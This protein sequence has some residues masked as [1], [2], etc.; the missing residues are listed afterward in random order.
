MFE[1]EKG[2]TGLETAIILIAFVVV[3][4]VLAYTVLSAG[5]FATQQSEQSIHAALKE[6]QSTLN[7]KGTIVGRGMSE[8]Y[9]FEGWIGAACVTSRA[10][11]NAT[12]IT[13]GQR[14]LQI[15]ITDANSINAGDIIAYRKL[16]DVVDLSNDTNLHIDIGWLDTPGIGNLPANSIAIVLD[17]SSTSHGWAE[18]I[19]LPILPHGQF[20]PNHLDL[21]LSGITSQY[22]GVAAIGLKVLTPASFTNGDKIEF[23]NVK[24]SETGR[25]L[26]DCESGWFVSDNNLISANASTTTK[27]EGNTSA[28]LTVAEAWN[29]PA[30]IGDHLISSLPT[31]LSE[32][33][34]VHLWFKTSV[35]LSGTLDDDDIQFILYENGG[36][37]EV[38]DI[39]ASNLDGDWHRLELSLS[40]NTSNYDAIEKIGLAANSDPGS[41]TFFI[42]TLETRPRDSL[43]C[44]EANYLDQ[45]VVSVSNAIGGEAIDFT[46]TIDSD[47]D[48]I[49]S[50]ES[51]P[52]HKVIISYADQYQYGNDLAWSVQRMGTCDSDYLLE[53]GEMFFIT[54]DLRYLNNNA[55]FENQ[56]IKHNRLFTIEIKPP[57]GAT[58]ATERDAPSMID[59]SNI[60]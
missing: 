3:A 18:Q 46:P 30:L 56:K 60:L 15:E 59:A 21:P 52:T 31:D 42:D 57:H 53:D 13:E 43:P 22:D 4:A 50:D 6:T 14:A 28:S 11:T 20:L 47:D 55:T 16:D 17:E 29:A 25:M 23:D 40:G 33:S 12:G 39:A 45:L 9:D 24:G 54:V 44:P 49:L 48:G 26:A 7:I 32:S 34:S 35:D 58:L 27:V 37:N 51:S 5:L 10:Y 8:V 1:H 36:G 41:V 2:I 38:L 19:N